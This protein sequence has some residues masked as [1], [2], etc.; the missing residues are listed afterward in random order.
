MESITP[1]LAIFI[2]S[3][4]IYGYIKGKKEIEQNFEKEI[5]Y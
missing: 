1:I 2:F 5:P 4:L 3:F